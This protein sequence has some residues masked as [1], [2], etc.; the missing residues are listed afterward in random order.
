MLGRSRRRRPNINPTLDKRIVFVG[1]TPLQAAQHKTRRCIKAGLLLVYRFRHWPNIKPALAELLVFAGIY[2]R[3]LSH[4][5]NTTCS[6]EKMLKVQF[7][8]KK[9]T[10]IKERKSVQ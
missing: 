3:L 8:H 9:K 2:H 6:R 7:S 4:P 1:G 5:L 10:E